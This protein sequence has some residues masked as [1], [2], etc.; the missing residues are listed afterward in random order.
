MRI[1]IQQ[2]LSSWGNGTSD[3]TMKFTSTFERG[4]GYSDHVLPPQTL[5]KHNEEKSM[6]LYPLGLPPSDVY[7]T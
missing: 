3:V 4:Y 6:T 5:N 7:F 1:W 2:L